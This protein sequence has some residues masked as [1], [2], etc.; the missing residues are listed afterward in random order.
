[1]LVS[2]APVG[3]H[4]SGAALASAFAFSAEQVDQRSGSARHYIQLRTIFN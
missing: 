3:D 4:G 1:M 2:T